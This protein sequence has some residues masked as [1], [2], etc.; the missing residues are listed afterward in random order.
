MVGNAVDTM[1]YVD[2]EECINESARVRQTVV[3]LTASKALTNRARQIAK[4]TSQKAVPRSGAGIAVEIVTVSSR[5][6][7]CLSVAS[8]AGSSTLKLALDI[9]IRGRNFVELSIDWRGPD[10]G[11]I[12]VGGIQAQLAAG[13][14]RI[15]GSK[16]VT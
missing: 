7:S 3:V 15:H 16:H 8:V 9:I 5:F 2:I 13:R 14:T 12:P 11:F 10:R 4:K 1:S 6:P